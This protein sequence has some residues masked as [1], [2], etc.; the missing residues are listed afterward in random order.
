MQILGVIYQATK[1]QLFR[2]IKGITPEITPQK[3]AIY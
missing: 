3:N 1:W 2:L